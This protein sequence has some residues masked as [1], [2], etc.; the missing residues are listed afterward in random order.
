MPRTQVTICG[1]PKAIAMPRIA[2]I[3]QPQDMRF[4]IAIAPEHHHQD[5]RDRREPGQN[6]GLQRRGAGHEGRGRLRQ[7][8]VGTAPQRPASASRS[9]HAG[10]AASADAGGDAAV[11]VMRD[12]LRGAV[13]IK[14][15]GRESRHARAKGI[16]TGRVCAEMHARVTVTAMLVYLLARLHTG[17]PCSPEALRDDVSVEECLDEL[18]EALR[19]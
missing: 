8:G 2:P 10:T 16:A 13:G 14:T 12:L 6:V 7:A 15:R 18:G 9:A 1:A 17:A 4:A 19:A 3:H 11:N 5:H